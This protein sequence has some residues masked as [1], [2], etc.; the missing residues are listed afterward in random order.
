M[1]AVRLGDAAG[2]LAIFT[3]LQPHHF[4]FGT[5]AHVETMLVLEFVMDTSQVTAAKAGLLDGLAATA[6]Q[7]DL[8]QLAKISSAIKLMP[9]RGFVDS[10][11]IITAAD[12]YAGIDA[13]LYIVSK[14]LDSAVAQ[15]TA[16]Y[17]EFEWGS[18]ERK[19]QV[20]NKINYR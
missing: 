6:R 15:H 14:I 13:S 18:N 7:A 12:S 9:V 20:L 16:D 17:I 19:L 1:I 3:A 10:G 2:H 11:K 8:E 5:T 4:R